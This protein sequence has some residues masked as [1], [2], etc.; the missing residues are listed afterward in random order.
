MIRIL[1]Q[2]FI[3]C[4]IVLVLCGQSNPPSQRNDGMLSASNTELLDPLIDSI[5]YHFAQANKKSAEELIL[6]LQSQKGEA[7]SCWTSYYHARLNPE[8]INHYLDSMQCFD[9]YLLQGYILY[10]NGECEYRLNQL[11]S[12][13]YFFEKSKV[14][15]QELNYAHGLIDASYMLAY[16]L[17]D[18][19]RPQDAI[20]EYLHVLGASQN[21]SQYFLSKVYNNIGI[22]Y[23]NSGD[24]S[25]A[26]H[27]YKKALKVKQKLYE[28]GHPSV[29]STQ[30]NIAGSYMWTYNFDSA[31]LKFIDIV[32]TMES[33]SRFNAC[34]KSRSYNNL[35]VVYKSLH[36][37][38][39]AIK[40]F[41]KSLQYISICDGQRK[42][43]NIANTLNN[44]AETFLLNG[45]LDKSLR[46][47]K[48]AISLISQSFDSL[49]I[50][51][52]LPYLCQAQTLYELGRFNQ[53]DAIYQ[54]AGKSI[55][56][57]SSDFDD[58]TKVKNYQ[59]FKHWI[60]T[61]IKI[62]YGI[63][64]EEE[65]SNE[66]IDLYRYLISFEQFL[67]ERFAHTKSNYLYA[68]QSKI[69]Y[70]ELIAILVSQNPVENIDEIYRLMSRL[71][72]SKIFQG[73][74]NTMDS[75]YYGVPV[76]IL[77]DLEI[78]QDS[79]H[80][81]SQNQ[82]KDIVST[83][84]SIFE[85]RVDSIMSVLREEYPE[86]V[87]MRYGYDHVPTD[88]LVSWSGQNGTSIVEYFYGDSAVYAI[89]IDNGSP[90]IYEL[91]KPVQLDKDVQMWLALLHNPS[92]NHKQLDSISNRIYNSILSP[93]ISK[94]S[95]QSLVIV[96]DDILGYCPFEA[97][98]TDQ[99]NR[100]YLFER[101]AIRYEYNS[102]LLIRNNQKQNYQ[103]SL[104][105]VAPEFSEGNV[106]NKLIAS[107]SGE[108]EDKSYSPLKYNVSEA[109][110]LVDMFGGILLT[111]EEATK[112]SV[113]EWSEQSKIIHIASHAR[114]TVEDMNTYI[115]LHGENEGE[116][117]LQNDILNHHF[118]CEMVVL[119]AC[120]TGSGRMLK[121][122]GVN[123]LSMSFR[124]AGAHSVFSTLWNANDKSTEVIMENFYNYLNEGLAKHDALRLAKIDYI[125]NNPHLGSHPY[126]W[127]GMVGFGDMTI[128]ELNASG[129]YTWYLYAL[130]IF[131]VFVIGAFLVKRRL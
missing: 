9:D 43:Q 61:K 99:N 4:L 2:T 1:L 37:Y 39:E 71:K 114:A 95:N 25:T 111:D 122:E 104:L 98:V 100:K 130:V 77:N 83:M 58:F 127:A 44:L 26:L 87:N 14:H 35:G 124:Y 129:K 73:L 18:L 120:N 131:L 67:Q 32:A 16:V 57:N 63:G 119:S 50:R 96:P 97:L 52:F 17:G 21:H 93:F 118:P 81:L 5:N 7:K 51:C 115:V 47:S 60:Y 54:K 36:R 62:I 110:K 33:D 82:H 92:S 91:C 76:K 70:E 6:K 11:D 13:A 64:K 30:E 65:L 24:I 19:N 38:N 107:R 79:L 3:L 117:L 28:P 102:T 84:Y 106:T 125:K 128:L 112:K 66:V 29:I 22:D 20:N 42:S 12:A 46:E 74:N 15:F 49:D 78:T 56:Y 116:W 48:R 109:T 126:Y 105:A 53:A 75:L 86:Y 80:A 27:Y 123:S 45:E 55:G 34:K 23:K 85:L 68:E 69:F 10:L 40:S 101:Y 108:L 94:I 113:Y 31:L 89:L 59:Y 88:S 8:T 41:D 103:Y 72:Y 90:T 121:G